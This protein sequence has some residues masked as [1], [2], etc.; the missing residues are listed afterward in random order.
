MQALPDYYGTLGIPSYISAY[1]IRRA[2]VRKSWEFHPD[3]HPNDPDSSSIM[4][5][6]NVAY[7]TL[8]DPV[9]RAKYDASHSTT[10]IRPSQHQK[11]SALT[12]S[13]H[14]RRTNRNKNPGIFDTALAMLS[15]LVSYVAATL[16]L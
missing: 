2:Y 5:D 3:L 6:I 14:R 13:H 15:R 8:S 4:S 9:T 16:P 12:K 7:A 1:G 11:T 10:Y